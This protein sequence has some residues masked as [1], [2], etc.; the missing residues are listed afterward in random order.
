MIAVAATQNSAGSDHVFSQN[1]HENISF[2]LCEQFSSAASAHPAILLGSPR[3]AKPIANLAPSAQRSSAP[4]FRRGE[5][6]PIKSI[7]SPVGRC[8]NNP[9]MR[10]RPLRRRATTIRREWHLMGYSQRPA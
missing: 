7:R 5:S 4:R 8:R 10:S 3:D 6:C 9:G 1:E 2:I